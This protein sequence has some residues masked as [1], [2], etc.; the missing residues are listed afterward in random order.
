M[1]LSLVMSK[2]RK[3]Q[4]NPDFRHRVTA[5]APQ[6]KEIES[7]LFELL[8]PG[9]FANVPMLLLLYSSLSE[10]ISIEMVFRSLYFF[11]RACLQK[12]QL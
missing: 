10:Q 4:G 2:P 11:N 3:K 7:R 1:V 9:T 5:P 8:S 12:P 6:S